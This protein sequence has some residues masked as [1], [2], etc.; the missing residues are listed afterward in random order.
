MTEDKQQVVRLNDSL[1]S[2][3][4]QLVNDLKNDPYSYR[5]DILQISGIDDDEEFERLESLL[6]EKMPNLV[7]THHE[8]DT[9]ED[10][11]NQLKRIK[12][13]FLNNMQPY[14]M[15][16]SIPKQKVKKKDN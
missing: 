4:E 15:D 3:A 14:F 5:M 9:P 2:F 11:S 1:D 8:T 16:F 13:I 12:N 10:L 7:I 6:I